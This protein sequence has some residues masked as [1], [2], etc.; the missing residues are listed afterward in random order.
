ML[1]FKD[2]MERVNETRSFYL[3]EVEVLDEDSYKDQHP[4]YNDEHA[5]HSKAKSLHTTGHLKPEYHKDGSATIHVK[6]Y[7]DTTSSTRITDGVHQNAGLYHNHPSK[8]I[9][10]GGKMADGGKTRKNAKTTLKEAVGFDIDSI[11]ISKL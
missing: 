6:P 9:A 2:L 5:A 4:G 3:E 11:D 1:R 8:K 10:K 7:N